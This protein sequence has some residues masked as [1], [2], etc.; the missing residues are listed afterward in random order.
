MSY[1]KE[2]G[3]PA[4]QTSV[5]HKT[6]WEVVAKYVPVSPDLSLAVLSD[7]SKLDCTGQKVDNLCNR[8]AYI[9]MQ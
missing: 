5:T 2:T 9:A 4:L 8:W 6:S 1:A 7:I 3:M